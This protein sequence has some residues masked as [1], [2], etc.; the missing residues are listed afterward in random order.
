MDWAHFP[1]SRNCGR[2][3][4]A[5]VAPPKQMRL[6]ELDSLRGLA[7][8]AVVIIHFLKL[9]A[10]DA[11]ASWV[12][13][14]PWSRLAVGG[15]AGLLFLFFVLSGLV[16]ALPWI[17]GRPQSY[18]TFVTR[19][20]FRIY[21]P[22]LAALAPA[23]AGAYWLH[24]AVTHSV[25]FQECWSEPVNWHLVW[26]H[27]LFVGNFNTDQFDAPIWSLVCEM[28]VSLIFPLLCASVLRFRNAWPLAMAVC[29]VALSAVARRLS[30][31][32]GQWDI[33]DTVFYSSLF[34]LGIWLARER[35]CI[36]VWFSLLSRR[37]RILVGVA[38]LF[39]ITVAG[40]WFSSFSQYLFH[41]G[42]ETIAHW[43]P[44]FGGGGMIVMSLNSPSLRRILHWPPILWLGRVSYSIY[45]LHF[46]FLLYCVHL[47]YGRISMGAI[48]FLAMVLTLAGSW[49]FYRLIELP[50]INLGR[51]IST[52]SIHH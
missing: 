20:I 22:Y 47:F 16:L 10:E 33:V 52:K 44:V 38:S 23:V 27:V 48:I 28:R 8:M 19:R 46:V 40:P 34:V 3:D 39:L 26:Q 29:L 30:P 6:I 18:F 13:R 35:T 5:T 45:L 7:C 43:I 21:V 25:W 32:L 36:A 15:E 1:R 51:Q 50:S 24:R 4:V 2:M 49:C 17:E 41:R 42:L 37:M 31:S 9:W 11:Q 12:D 14:N